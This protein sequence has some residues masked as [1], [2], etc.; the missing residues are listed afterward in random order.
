MNALNESK[1][2][3]SRNRKLSEAKNKSR[4]FIS[5]ESILLIGDHYVFSGL[6][7]TLFFTGNIRAIITQLLSMWL[8][9]TPDAQ[10]QTY[11]KRLCSFFKFW[12]KGFSE[13]SV[14]CLRKEKLVVSQ[15]L[16]HFLTDGY[17]H[18]NNTQRAFD[19][20]SGWIKNLA[21]TWQ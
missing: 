12:I 3:W 9:W 19:V 10:E 2:G 5:L 7:L 18:K 14:L 11:M 4:S 13:L 8:S 1:G 20:N 15:V 6:I 17:V 21:L 16:I